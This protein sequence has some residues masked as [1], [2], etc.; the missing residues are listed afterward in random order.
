MKEDTPEH[1]YESP[2]P[3]PSRAV[4]QIEKLLTNTRQTWETESSGEDDT[5]EGSEP[6]KPDVDEYVVLSKSTS[7]E[8]IGSE[9]GSVYKRLS[10][11]FSE[12]MEYP[13]QECVPE[14]EEEPSKTHKPPYRKE[15][16]EAIKVEPVNIT[17]SCK[18]E[19][20]KADRRVSPLVLRR[21]QQ[22]V[23]HYD[24]E[25]GQVGVTNLSPFN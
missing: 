16:E 6:R 21:S 8:D 15:D 17:A 13:R 19:E 10:R 9:E 11:T 23:H 22:Y 4:D 1:E 5:E 20:L 7:R 14:E 18:Q 12:E 25:F 3:S 24:K 2:P